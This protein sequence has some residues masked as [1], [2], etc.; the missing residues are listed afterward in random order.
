MNG[1]L[2]SIRDRIT[3]QQAHVDAL[4]AEM[5]H[6]ALILADQL[7]LGRID[8]E[9]I[10]EYEAARAAWEQAVRDLDHERTQAM[11]ENTLALI[12]AITDCQPKRRFEVVR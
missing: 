4:L 8:D 3:R 10:D 5:H 11:R 7:T 6:H 2:R 9:S 1:N 12:H